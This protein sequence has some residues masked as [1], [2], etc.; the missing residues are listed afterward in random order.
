MATNNYKLIQALP[1]IDKKG[2]LN[3]AINISRNGKKRNP[4]H[5]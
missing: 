1:I 5:K 2:A 3:P 4:W